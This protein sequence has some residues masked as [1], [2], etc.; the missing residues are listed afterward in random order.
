MD[1]VNDAGFTGPVPGTA[2]DSELLARARG[3][4]AGSAWWAERRNSATPMSS[5]HIMRT[6]IAG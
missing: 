2:A 6:N 4:T 1:G 3:R 5:S